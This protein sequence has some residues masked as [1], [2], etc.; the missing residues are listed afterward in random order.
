MFAILQPN[1]A[2][3]LGVLSCV[4]CI[5]AAAFT[6]IAAPFNFNKAMTISVSSNGRYLVTADTSAQYIRV[7]DMSSPAAWLVMSSTRM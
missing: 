6:P 2:A 4:V 5:A 1:S 3:I 7:V